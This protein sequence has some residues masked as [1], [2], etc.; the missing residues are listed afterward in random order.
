MTQ[1]IHNGSLFA[2]LRRTLLHN[3]RVP[4]GLLSASMKV[5]AAVLSVGSYMLLV[6]E[7]SVSKCLMQMLAR[8]IDSL[9]RGQKS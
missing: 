8:W 5:L 9:M 4:L 2:G 6:V 1:K 3:W 7:L